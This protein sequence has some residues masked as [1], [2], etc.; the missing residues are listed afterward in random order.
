MNRAGGPPDMSVKRISPEEALD[1]VR[2]Q[3]Y[4]YKADHP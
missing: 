4:V 2:D 3:G 1:L